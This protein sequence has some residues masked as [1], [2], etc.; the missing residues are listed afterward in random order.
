VGAPHLVDR[1]LGAA[2]GARGDGRAHGPAADGARAGT[3][4]RGPGVVEDAAARARGGT[5]SGWQS[6]PRGAHAARVAG[7]HKSEADITGVVPP[8]RRCEC[9]AAGDPVHTGAGRTHHRLVRVRARRG[10]RSGQP[11]SGGQRRRR[12]AGR[13]VLAARPDEG[14]EEGGPGAYLPTGEGGCTGVVRGRPGAV[15]ERRPPRRAC[16]RLGRWRGGTPLLRLQ[17]GQH[18]DRAGWR[19]LVAHAGGVGSDGGGRGRR[20]TDGASLAGG[21]RPVRGRP[22]R[23]G[24]EPG[25]RGGG[26]WAAQPQAARGKSRQRG[27][28]RPQGAAGARGRAGGRLWGVLP[29][30]PVRRGWYRVRWVHGGVRAG[31]ASSNQITAKV[32][33]IRLFLQL[34]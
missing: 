1:R 3:R 26:P 7:L 13:G 31:C 15:L 12:R 20:G 27:E 9:R 19:G 30:V 28:G 33:F 16:G 5:V 10:R 6:L 2:E 14:G 23:G 22:G 18:R 24:G 4:G 29:A 25:R 11:V 34:H 17:E 21:V 32:Y 8:R